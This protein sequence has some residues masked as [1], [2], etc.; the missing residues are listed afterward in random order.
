MLRRWIEAMRLRTLPV[1]VAGVIAGTA[2]A[3]MC[4]GFSVLPALLCLLF[5]M[6]AQIASN[7][8]N[9]YYDFKNGLDK[10]GRAGFRRG[11]TE[12]DISPSAMKAATYLTLA[13]AAVV[14]LMLLFF[15][16]WWLI[17]VGA[18][19]GVFALAYSAGPYPL[20]HHG[21]GDV[22]VVI[23]FG[24]VPVTFTCY[25]QTHDWAALPLLLPTAVATGFVA[26]NVLIVNNYRDAEDDASVGK[27]TTVVIFGRRVMGT[28]YLLSGLLA[29][30]L[31]MPVWV[32]L[33][34]Y[35]LAVPAVYIALHVATWRKVVASRGAA[36]N[37]LLGRSAVNLLVFALLLLVAA[38][39][40]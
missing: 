15:G 10:K 17:I 20:S 40:G 12:G 5:A 8:G 4:G 28:C 29:M 2:C 1:S 36:L 3:V 38:V 22:A 34:L 39:L 13:A 19:I 18:L 14:G 30:L 33:G 32:K 24:V 37:P 16:E 9:E 31:M 6:L 11:V 23:F 21:L 7:F 27:R 25:L 26:A 35:S